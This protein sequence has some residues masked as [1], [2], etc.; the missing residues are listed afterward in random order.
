MTLTA[1]REWRRTAGDGTFVWRGLADPNVEESD[2]AWRAFATLGD[3]GVETVGEWS[4][5]LHQAS[6][7]GNGASVFDYAF[8]VASDPGHLYVLQTDAACEWRDG[9]WHIVG[10]EPHLYQLRLDAQTARGLILSTVCSPNRKGDHACL[11]RIASAWG[12]A[13]DTPDPGIFLLFLFST[14]WRNTI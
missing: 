10:C 9:R 11:A 12:I 8:T 4:R 7:R 1:Y 13:F 3:I 5:P 6:A 14:P 2:G